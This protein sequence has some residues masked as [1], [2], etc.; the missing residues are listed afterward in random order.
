MGSFP[1]MEGSGSFFFV[2]E[3]GFLET[4]VSRIKAFF[5]SVED[6]FC[7]QVICATTVAI[8]VVTVLFN[9]GLASTMIDYLGIK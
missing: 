8:V 9:G 6:T 1:K 4:S 2:I 7:V 5:V 3:V